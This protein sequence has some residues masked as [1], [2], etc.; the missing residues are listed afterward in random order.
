MALDKNPDHHHVDDYEE[1]YSKAYKKDYPA[2]EK[3]RQGAGNWNSKEDAK[4]LDKG[5][6]K[7]LG[8]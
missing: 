6:S 4:I 7:I 8:D 2:M 1:R 3:A 5:I